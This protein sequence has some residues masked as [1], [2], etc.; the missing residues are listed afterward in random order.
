MASQILKQL[1]ADQSSEE[2]FFIYPLKNGQSVKL[3]SVLNT[4]FGNSTGGSSGGYQGQQSQHSQTSGSSFGSSGGGLTGGSGSGLGG[5]GGGGGTSR[6]TSGGGTGIGSRAGQNGSGSGGAGLSGTAT[7]AAGELTGQVF[8]VSNDDTNSLLVTTATRYQDKVRQIIAELDR[9]VPQVLIKVLI[10]EVTHDSSDDLGMDFSVLDQRKSGNGSTLLQNLGNAASNTTNG[11][12]ALAITE[13]NFTATLH[14]LAAADKLD[15]LSRP[16][17]LT[18]DNQEATITV[19]SEEPFITNSRIDVNNATINT[20]QYQDI[21]IILDVTPHI[22]PDGLVILDVSAENS[23][24]QN[25]AGVQIT[26]GVTAPVFLKRSAQSRVG[27]IDGQ[28][29]VIG[30]LM[31]DQKTE[32]ITKVPLLGDLPGVGPFFQR[33]QDTKTKTE[34]LIFLTPHV[35]QKPATLAIWPKTRCTGPG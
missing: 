10:A 32:T 18:S 21:G 30:G 34:L 12:L 25:G 9:P 13:T 24:P 17:I 35:A 19:G 22:N 3:A 26:P 15:V 31:E 1:D 28:T 2:T 20:I 14:A 16:Y 6:G 27:I 11:G 29:I 33:R 5:S 7:R 4:L 23:Q 8:V